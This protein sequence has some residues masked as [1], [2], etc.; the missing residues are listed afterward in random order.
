[1]THVAEEQRVF[2]V[3]EGEFGFDAV[4][5]N[6][7]LGEPVSDE[8]DTFAFFRRCDDLRATGGGRTWFGFEGV[9]RVVDFRRL[10]GGWGLLRRGTVC[11]FRLFRG[12]ILTGIGSDF[13]GDRSGGVDRRGQ[14]Q[15]SD[16]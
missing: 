9:W 4:I 13:L 1:M 12:L 2:R 14:G 7:A 3:A 5:V 10:F 16:K 8:H 11:A 6:I 15:G